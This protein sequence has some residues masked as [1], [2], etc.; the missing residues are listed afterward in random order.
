MSAA[1]CSWRIRT[2][3]FSCSFNIVRYNGAMWHIGKTALLYK[4]SDDSGMFRRQ[5]YGVV[6]LSICSR[7]DESDGVKQHLNQ[8]AEVDIH[9]T[10]EA[11][12]S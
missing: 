9:G 2:R 4:G 3:M 6:G 7:S 11:S 5:P 1:L 10:L 8:Q 12:R